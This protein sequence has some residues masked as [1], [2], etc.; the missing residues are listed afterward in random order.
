MSKIYAMEQQKLRMLAQSKVNYFFPSS[1][2]LNIGQPSS[3]GILRL[4]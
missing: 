3:S 4:Q 1:G 2:Y